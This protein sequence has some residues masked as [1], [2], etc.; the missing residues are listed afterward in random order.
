MVNKRRLLLIQVNMQI[1][2]CSQKIKAETE[3]KASLL[4]ARSVQTTK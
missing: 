2:P 3:M 1:A 4:G